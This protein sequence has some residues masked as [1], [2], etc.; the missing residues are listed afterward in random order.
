[1]DE[2]KT[3]PGHPGDRSQVAAEKLRALR[4]RANQALDDHRRRLADL[5]SQLNDRVHQLAE[6]FG[7]SPELPAELP[8]SPPPS[9]D[10]EVEEL[11]RQVDEGRAKHEKFIE[12]LAAARR[13]LEALQSQS[14]DRCG[15]AEE[16][17]EEARSEVRKLRVELEAA[18]TLHEEERARHDKF[19][20]QLA[21]ARQALSELQSA[22]G[23]RAAE[24]VAELESTRAAKAELVAE[25]ESARAAKARLAAE[26]ETLAKAKTALTAE[27]ESARTAGTASAVELESLNAAKM[28]LSAELSAELAAARAAKEDAEGRLA[29]ASRDLDILHVEVDELSAKV[30]GL[31]KDLSAAKSG[32]QVLEAR[33]DELVKQHAADSAEIERL[34][35]LSA[36]EAES[37]RAAQTT[38]ASLQ[39]KVESL[40]GELKAVRAERDELAR[41]QSELEAAKAS[42]DAALANLKSVGEADQQKLA[43]RQAATQRE[44]ASLVEQLA[45]AGEAKLAIEKSLAESAVAQQELR[46]S[47]ESATEEL[48]R[49][50][51]QAVEAAALAVKLDQ[52]HA[53]I[54]ELREAA[55][56][57][58]E[59]EQLQHKFDLALADVQKL[60]R[61]SAALREELSQRPAASDQESPELI[62]VRS[63]RDALALRVGELEA[64]AAKV[65][66]PEA[67]QAQD[68]LQRRFEM[69]VDDV[70]QLKHENAQL[71]DKLAAAAKGA[72]PALGAGSGDNDWAAQRARL[73]AALE[74]EDEDGPVSGDR[75][76]ERATI[77]G[78]IAATDRAV[79]EKD[80]EI[81]ELRA[82]LAG[83]RSTRGVQEEQ[84]RARHELL[85]ADETIAAERKHIAELQAQWEDK[86]RSA[87]LEI[88]VERARL[89]RE[90]AALKEKMLELELGLPQARAE[91]GGEA[92][93]RRRWLT[94]LG[95]GDETDE[96]KKK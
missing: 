9:R 8:S 60:K 30:A 94:A 5:E 48:A 93:P 77:E 27:L 42:L 4:E 55:Q 34:T 37:V 95:L 59:L 74:E 17:A 16:A 36:A 18:T 69:A 40:Q 33:V 24:L 79:A 38:G 86:V 64:A 45:A 83:N 61:E 68:D 87:E 62:A 3:T 57:Q 84:E 19:A 2:P 67:R 51:Q 1:M 91:D 89:A 58:K 23:D 47:L 66:D 20:A 70:R 28:E 73:M 11:R 35:G 82:E 85:D 29:A 31:D 78:A 12:Q 53:E 92:K 71:R 15:Q 10:V 32:H 81:A 80:Q 52:A 6:E 26:V 88:S 50:Q 76:K 54:D 72:L 90:Q 96:G 46:T 13:Q 22:S 39:E 65:D 14:C 41:K 49:V 44:I 56:S 21:Q 7:D 25:L 43:E 75:K 63:E